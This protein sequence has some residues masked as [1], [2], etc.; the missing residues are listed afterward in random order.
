M[1]TLVSAVY[2]NRKAE[3][4]LPVVVYLLMILI[5]MAGIAGVIAHVLEL[6]VLYLVVGSGFFTGLIIWHQKQGL[7]DMLSL[8]A[9]KLRS[10][11]PWIF[12]FLSVLFI[13]ATLHLRVTNWDDMNYWAIFPKNIAAINGVPTGDRES[14]FFR[15]YIP[16]IQYL[17]YPA[18]KLIGHFSEPAMFAVDYILIYLSL[19]PL[20]CRYEKQ[21]PA[22]YLSSVVLGIILP[23]ILSFQ[24]LH[25]LGVDIIMTFLFGACIIWVLEEERNLFSLLRIIIATT[26]LTL[27]KTTGCFFA[28]VIIVLFIV[29]R[30]KKS[31]RFFLETAGLIASNVIFY[32]SWR[33][34]CRIK[35]NSTYLSD[36]LS[37]N[38]KGAGIR[39]PAY[40]RDT[41][42]SFVR[43]LFSLHLNDGK[44]GLSAMAMLGVFLII[45]VWYHR[46]PLADRRE[47]YAFFVLCGGL[48]VYLCLVL[49]TYLFVFEEWEAASL[50]S[51]DRYLTTYFG[52]LFYFAL[53]LFVRL[54]FGTVLVY[55]VVTAAFLV[56]LN[57]PY[58]AKTLIPAGFQNEYGDEVSRMDAIDR[59][60]QS[61]LTPEMQYGAHILFVDAVDD[62][63]RAKMIPYCAV[64]YVVRITN[65]A[66]MGD[67]TIRAVMDAAEDFGAA[68]IV[69]LDSVE[70]LMQEELPAYETD[71]LY[72]YEDIK[73]MI[74]G[75]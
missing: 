32:L 57:Y 68:Y 31:V 26:V 49:Y 43:A 29:T 19:L 15:D 13:F 54:P 25:C 40:T 55:P 18:F 38:L 23:F 36:N 7:R 58:M 42:Q 71:V 37:N 16:I 46:R 65:P 12:V 35:G 75:G 2:F 70:E 45:F 22:A 33:I 69:F 39:F 44:F 53:Y 20:F 48:I 4:T 72:L 24:M 30:E 3:E 66:E 62:M 34:F 47:L 14:T 27:S 52:A 59:E 21:S 5:Y 61:V 56:T 11:A 1:L 41:V 74:R 6:I 63:E 9:A 8:C 67:L 17:Y 28:A 60:L 64:P 51:A 73:E 50:S 10:P